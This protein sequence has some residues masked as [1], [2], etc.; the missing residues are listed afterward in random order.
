MTYI[1]LRRE[2]ATRI[3]QHAFQEK[4]YEACGL[5]VGVQ[6]EAY[7]AIPIPNIA[8][9]PM[10]QFEMDPA[11]LS[12]HLPRLTDGGLSLLA[13]YHSHPNGSAI[14]SPSDIDEAAYPDIIHVLIGLKHQKPEI[15]AWQIHNWRVNPI[16][17]YMGDDKPK[18]NEDSPLSKAQTIA[19]IIGAI[20]AVAL[21]IIMSVSLLPPAS[22][23]PSP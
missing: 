4:P 3:I 12:K 17:I 1:W 16:K 23:I 8:T 15:N 11:A 13:F 6:N 10:T 2:L 19:I 5:I 9:D 21:L 20:V 14:P 22:P 18:V 7:E